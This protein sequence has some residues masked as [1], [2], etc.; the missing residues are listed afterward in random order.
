V[1]VRPQRERRILVAEELAHL[2]DALAR[3]EQDAGGSVAERVEAEALPRQARG[4]P[5]RV[6][7]TA[8]D[9]LVA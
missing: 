2:E 1:D 7:D 5:R 4:L 8:A 9:V 6:Q 3:L